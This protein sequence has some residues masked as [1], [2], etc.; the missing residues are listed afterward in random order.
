MLV[1]SDDASPVDEDSWVV[2]CEPDSASVLDGSADEL[3]L[4]EAYPSS[5]VD[6][7]CSC[8]SVVAGSVALED[9]YSV[10]GYSAS[11]AGCSAEVEVEGAGSTSL[12]A[13]GS[14]VVE[15]ST[16]GD[17]SAACPAL[18]VST[19]ASVA[20]SSFRLMGCRCY[21]FLLRA[22]FSI[23]GRLTI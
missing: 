16:S 23:F 3:V 17:A 12:P 18:S 21:C 1:G 5:V 2:G 11:P 8:F 7:A 10:A 9:S 14:A 20:K 4:V 22:N 13:S 15:G 6:D 19:A